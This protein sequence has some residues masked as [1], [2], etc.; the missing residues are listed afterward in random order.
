VDGYGE[1]VES[2]ESI[3]RKLQSSI[4]A[5]EW[6]LT[7]Y[8]LDI[9]GDLAI[10]SRV[11]V[12][13]MLVVAIVAADRASV[14]TRGQKGRGL[15]ALTTETSVWRTIDV[16]WRDLSV[17]VPAVLVRFVQS[18]R[19]VTERRPASCTHEGVGRW[20]QSRV[21]VGE[22]HVPANDGKRSV[23]GA[24]AL[25][26]DFVGVHAGL[27]SAWLLSCKGVR[28]TLRSNAHSGFVRAIGR[29]M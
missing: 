14:E 4:V 22:R 25:Q 15:H 10:K 28:P 24:R 21:V 3:S 17:S 19:H 23:Y 27:Y 29:A 2:G 16:H 7:F 26:A 8:R 20:Q 6:I 18:F 9:P 13:D 12:C 1:T 5:T 11:R